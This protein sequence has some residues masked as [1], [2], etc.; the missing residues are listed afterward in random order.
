MNSFIQ[1]WKKYALK[2]ILVNNTA[3]T[4][5]LA[6]FHNAPNTLANEAGAV[7]VVGA[8][9]DSPRAYQLMLAALDTL[10]KLYDDPLNRFRFA[11]CRCGR[12]I[13]LFIP[14]I[15]S[16]SELVVL[17][18]IRRNTV[19]FS[20]LSNRCLMFAKHLIIL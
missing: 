12:S 7:D 15:I 19:M 3:L 11:S 18:W 1:I 14:K 13:K 16:K 20:S 9:L 10:A 6:R 5:V 2:Y 8:G 4:F 17:Y